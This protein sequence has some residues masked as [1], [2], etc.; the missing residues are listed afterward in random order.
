METDFPFTLTKED[1]SI[2]ATSTTDSSYIRYLN[3]IEVDDDA[4]TFVALFGGAYSGEFHISIRHAHFGLVGTE[5]LNLDVSASV[6]SFTPTAG[7]IYGGTLITITGNNFGN[8]YTDNPVQISS[9]GAIDSKDCFVQETSGTEIK[10]RITRDLNMTLNQIDKIVVFLKAS[11]EAVCDPSSK[12]DY[13]WTSDIP[14]LETSVLS[15]DVSSNEWLLTVTGTD[16]TGDT[17]SVELFIEDKIQTT[18]SVS[19][20]EAVF[21]IVDVTS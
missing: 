3:I 19:T 10:C 20:T 16:F 12:C 4:K 18:K 17:S 11:E 5:G 13:T 7:S 21:T 8:V 15:F 14:I 9:N 2:N 1:L 6:T